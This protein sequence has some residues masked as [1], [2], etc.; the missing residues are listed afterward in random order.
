MNKMELLKE[1]VILAES[2][3]N[4]KILSDDY[5]Y[6]NE[7]ITP[8]EKDD[9]LYIF[10][11]YDDYKI[12]E[13]DYLFSII[14]NVFEYLPSDEIVSFMQ[15]IMFFLDT[16]N[17]KITNFLFDKL[18]INPFFII[19]FFCLYFTNKKN[20][21][22]I[23]LDSKT[24]NRLYYVR[25]N[26]DKIESDDILFPSDLLEKVYHINKLFKPEFKKDN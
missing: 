25:R 19:N 12:T 6:L 23:D 1:R 26:A 15:L 9:L 7:V 5:P 20:C 8:K 21:A 22:R 11:V 4:E 24:T 13:K 3:L 2:K 17:R 10:K 16:E 14:E 18:E